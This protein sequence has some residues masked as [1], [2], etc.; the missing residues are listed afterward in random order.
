MSGNWC[1]ICA[2]NNLEEAKKK[3]YSILE[4]NG[5]KVLTPYIN[6]ITMVEIVC[7]RGHIYTQVPSSTN[8]GFGFR[9]CVGNTT[10]QGEEHFQQAVASKGGKILGQYTKVPVLCGNQ[11]IFQALPSSITRGQ[12]CI[13]CAD[14]CPE[15][16][17]DRFI[18]LGIKVE[19]TLIFILK[20]RL[21]VNGNIFLK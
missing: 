14:E 13:K 15:Q 20:L 11:H 16:A 5:A 18:S 19:H 8:C 1:N 12:W 10:E 6:S 2:G 21:S 3:F 17:R 4:S 9:Y 7:K